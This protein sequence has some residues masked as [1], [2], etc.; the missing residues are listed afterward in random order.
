MNTTIA[1]SEE[2]REEIQKFGNKGETYNEI[3]AR[4]LKSAKERQLH[5]LLMDTSESTPV[6]EAL[7]RARKQWR[8]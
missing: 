8:K 4:I 2:I 3:L 6:S 7:E 1:V 5:D